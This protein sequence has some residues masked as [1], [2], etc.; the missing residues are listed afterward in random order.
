MPAGNSF[1]ILIDFCV[2]PFTISIMQVLCF[3]TI[4][5]L[6]ISIWLFDG[7]LWL[8]LFYIYSALH[9]Y[10]CLVL[11]YRVTVLYLAFC[12]IF[13][14]GHLIIGLQISI[15]LKWK[16]RFVV[17]WYISQ[18]FHRFFKH[19]Q[20]RLDSLEECFFLLQ[21]KKMNYSHLPELSLYEAL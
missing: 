19:I 18:N 14:S 7:Y 11:W 15:S 4:T 2:W 10:Y 20:R 1:L 3:N 12:W 9:V 17:H 8:A 13:V 21:L 6:Q 5:G 16:R